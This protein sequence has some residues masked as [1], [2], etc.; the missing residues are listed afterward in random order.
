MKWGRTVHAVLGTTLEV[1]DHPV[2]RRNSSAKPC[3]EQC[4]RVFLLRRHFGPLVVLFDRIFPRGIVVL[5]VDQ[6]D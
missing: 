6:P 2:K 3:V 1:L 4:L 5:S